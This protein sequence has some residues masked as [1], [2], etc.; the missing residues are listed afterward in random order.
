VRDAPANSTW[1][2]TWVSPD[3]SQSQTSRQITVP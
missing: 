1:R 3:R 2:A